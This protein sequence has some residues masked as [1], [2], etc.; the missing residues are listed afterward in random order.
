MN[1]SPS[2]LDKACAVMPDVICGSFDPLNHK[3]YADLRFL[4]QHEIDLADEGEVELDSSERRALKRYIEW[5]DKRIAKG[6]RA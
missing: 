5:L 3:T 6:N 2:E 4:A 1:L